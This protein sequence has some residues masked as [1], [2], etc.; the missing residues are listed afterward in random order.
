LIGEGGKQR[1]DGKKYGGEG[2][3][4]IER[5]GG[6]EGNG[7]TSKLKFWVRH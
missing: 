1:E 5:R 7:S 6:N 2:M 3:E 4:G